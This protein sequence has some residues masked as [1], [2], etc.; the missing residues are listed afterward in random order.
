MIFTR[1]QALNYIAS[2]PDLIIAFGLNIPAAFIHFLKSGIKEGRNINSFNAINYLKNYSDLREVYGSNTVEA[3]KHFINFGFKEGRSDSFVY[4]HPE[5][6]TKIWRTYNENLSQFYIK[7]NKK[8]L[9]NFHIIVNF[10]NAEKYIE[11]CIRSIQSQSIS[12]FKVT[13]IDDCSQDKT[14]EKLTPLV[15]D[16]KRFKLII[17]KNNN[18]KLANIV[19]ALK[20]K[21]ED[22]NKI[23]NVLLDGDDYLIADDVLDL[24]LFTYLKTNCLLTYGSYIR[25]SDGKYF[26]QK[27]TFRSINK[28]E[29]RKLPFLGSHLKTFRHDL[30]LNINQ[31]DFRDENGN[32]Y[33]ISDDIAFMLPMLEMAGFRQELI[34][35][36]LYIYNDLNP[37]NDHKLNLKEQTLIDQK[38]RSKKSY[39]KINLP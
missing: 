8:E 17:N 3:T 34:A 31:N 16:D 6:N 29:Y 11:K 21:S 30:Y 26:S 25:E 4:N 2:N 20:I 37:I 38:I 13:L 1:K 28:N 10:Y 32:I 35:D 18:K 24:I 9:F 5:I 14:I 15:K 23:I 7:E 33:K 22:P 39:P 12:N 19:N 36:P 27:Y